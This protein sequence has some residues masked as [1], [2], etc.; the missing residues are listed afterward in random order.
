VTPGL[1]PKMPMIYRA[2]Q[3]IY[4]LMQEQTICGKLLSAWLNT[5]NIVGLTNR[6]LSEADMHEIS[7]LILDNLCIAGSCQRQLVALD[8]LIGQLSKAIRY[9]C[10][11]DVVFL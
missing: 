10:Y 4:V 1:I 9:A 8:L 3:A 6:M 2:F 7:A 11:L 5:G